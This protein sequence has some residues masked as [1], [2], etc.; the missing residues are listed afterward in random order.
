M[1][2]SSRTPEGDPNHCPVCGHYLRLEPSRPPGDAPCPACGCLLW[3]P[4]AVAPG[5]SVSPEHAPDEEPA[6]PVLAGGR[7]RVGDGTFT[8][9]E[10]RV[11]AL[12]DPR[13]R[14]RLT[15]TI[16]GRPVPVELEARQVESA[17]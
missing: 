4:A 15:L 12:S 9:L 14:V 17:G 5:R 10:G 1:V 16:F 11:E 3:F 13:G 6:A 7:A 2:I 8:G